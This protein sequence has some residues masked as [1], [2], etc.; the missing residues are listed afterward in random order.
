MTNNLLEA[1]DAAGGDE[2]RPPP[3]LRP[4]DEGGFVL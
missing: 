4:L 3:A 2:F 1:G